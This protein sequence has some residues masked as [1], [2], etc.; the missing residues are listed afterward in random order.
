MSLVVSLDPWILL[1]YFKILSL[2]P[3]LHNVYFLEEYFV[4][5]S[6]YDGVLNVFV[7]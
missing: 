7:S 3:V 2:L 4:R 5:F 6:E 1:T